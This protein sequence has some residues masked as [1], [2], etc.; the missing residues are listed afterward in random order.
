MIEHIELTLAPYD[1]GEYN[2]HVQG[3]VAVVD[4][5]SLSKNG[6]LDRFVLACGMGDLLDGVDITQWY[7]K[8]ETGEPQ[9]VIAAFRVSCELVKGLDFSI[10][11]EWEYEFRGLVDIV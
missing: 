8:S 5:R 6:Q 11:V 9:N 1:P 7:G 4:Y 3:E 10:D 2:F